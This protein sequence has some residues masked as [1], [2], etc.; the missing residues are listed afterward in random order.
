MILINKSAITKYL[1][2]YEISY[3]GI[4]IWWES[5]VIPDVNSGIKIIYRFD[6]NYDIKALGVL[7]IKQSKICHLSTDLAIRRTG[8]A[9]TILNN[10]KKEAKRCNISSLWCHGPEDIGL[11]F[12]KLYNASIIGDT[13]NF[14]RTNGQ[15]DIILKMGI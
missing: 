12:S 13:H 7:D 15:N 9:T 3:P 4:N 11:Q 14:G 8:I 6:R 5:R 1:E 2:N 10:M